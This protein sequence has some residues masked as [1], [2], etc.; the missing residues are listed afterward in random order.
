VNVIR[1]RRSYLNR[2][3]ISLAILCALIVLPGTSFCADVFKPPHVSKI[4]IEG[5]RIFSDGKLKGVMKTKERSILRPFRK[6]AFRRDFLQADIESI[7]GLYKRHGHLKAKIDSQSVE[8]V[9]EGKAVRVYLSIREGPK[10]L[11]D[12]VSLE[13]VSVLRETKVSKGLRLRIGA[14]FD[15]Y[16]LE[17]DKRKILERYAEAG[18]VYASVSDNTVF[19]GDR[20]RVYYIV[21]EGIQA[22]AGEIRVGGNNVTGQWLVKREV[23]LR[24]GDILRRSE[25]I[26]TQQRIYD[27]GLYSDVRLSSLTAD[28]AAAV[29]DL[30]VIVKERKMAWVGTG[31]GYGSSDQLR[32]FGEW[33]HRNVLRSGQRFFTSANFAFGRWLFSQGKAVLDETRFE[34]GTVEPWLFGT[35]TAGQLILYHEY[36]REAAFS[37]DFNG[38]TFTAKRDLSSFSK[39]FISYDNRWVHTTDPAAIWREYVTRSLYLSVLRDT[40][41]DI[42]DPGRGSYQDLSWKI[43]GGALGGN[44]SFQKVSFSSSWYSAVKEIVLAT[45]VKVG[46]AEPFGET[47]GISPWE[48]IPF[49]E[50]FRTGGATSVRGYVEDDELGPRDA[51]GTVTGGRLMILTN[52]EARFPLFWKV[53]GAVFVDG[54][55]VWRSSS[56]VRFRSFNPGVSITGDSDYRYSYGGGLRLETPVGP[57]RVDYGRKL[58]LSVHDGDDRGQFHFSLGQAF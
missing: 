42:F 5:N 36:K 7:L 24:P 44:Y 30:M 32:V 37:E 45:R 14:P 50:R 38:F 55:N 10:T 58:R 26:R 25:L 52:V 53:S 21:K 19:E 39:G 27:T 9:K 41:D 43:A 33:G 3:L 8:K 12:A 20:A 56:E 40:R 1:R 57:V 46:F 35:R 54:G 23:T 22:R 49:Q 11:V 17:E 13:G 16:S 4:Q 28:S 29:V 47:R 34:I 6:S 48:R 18:Y 2:N 51:E 31:I 15:P